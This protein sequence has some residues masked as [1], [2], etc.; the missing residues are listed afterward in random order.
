MAQEAARTAAPGQARRSLHGALRLV[1]PANLPSA[2]ADALAGAAIVG[3]AEPGVYA[4]LALSGVLLYAGGVAL[5]DVF[6]ADLDAAER[7]ERPIP[8]GQVSVKGGFWLGAALMAS[9]AAAAFTVN[10]V[11]GVVATAV[12]YAAVVYDR[13]AKPNPLWGPL[14]MGAC[15]GLNLLLGMAAAP[16][17]MPANAA[18][19]LVPVLYVAA[20]TALSRGEN[21]RAAPRDAAVALAAALTVMAAQASFGFTGPGRWREGLVFVAVFGLMVLPPFWRA[22]REPRP[23]TVRAAVGAGVLGITA[24]DAAWVGYRLGTPWGAGVLGLLVLSLALR[25]RFAVT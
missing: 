10:V 15:R 7:P 1:R 14:V 18:W 2:A 3:V 4:T 16:L 11:A 24:I 12:A 6:D 9:G 13:W 20:L 5:N 17:L 25:K 23:G 8:S 22:R 21:G 19:A